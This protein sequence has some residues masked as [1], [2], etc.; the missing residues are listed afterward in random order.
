MKLIIE[1]VHKSFSDNLVIKGA[2]YEFKQGE[3]YALLGRNGSGKT[4]L[5]DLISN[6]KS[7]DNGSIEI[8]EGGREESSNK[9]TYSIW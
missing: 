1:E 6:K 7:I 4:T 2:S 3:I 8:E 5:F 9:K